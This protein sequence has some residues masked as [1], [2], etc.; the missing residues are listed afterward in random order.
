MRTRLAGR[1][2]KGELRKVG[3]V[4]IFRVVLRRRRCG[5]SGVTRMAAIS[6]GG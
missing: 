1:L 2:L 6:L 5:G 4:L 3:R